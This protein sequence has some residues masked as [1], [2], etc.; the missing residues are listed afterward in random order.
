MFDDIP[1]IVSNAAL[2][3]ANLS[4]HELLRAAFSSQSGLLYRPISMLSF[5]FNLYFFGNNS[6]SFKLTNLFIHLV[7]A[8]LILWLTRRL[9]L[10]CRRR[11]QFEW[12]DNSINWASPLIAAAWALH[13]L[14][15]EPVLFI[16]QRMTELAALF[17]LAGLIAYIYGRE[18]MQAGK[19]GWPLVWILTPI[20][21]VIG[22]LCKEDAALLPLYLLVIEWLIFGFRNGHHKI[23]KNILLF[24][25]GGL[26]LPGILGLV[27]LLTHPGYFLGGY[28]GR[29]FTL[30]QRLLTEF[31]VVFLYIQWTFI[32]D[33]RQLALYHDDLTV[34]TGLLTPVTTLLSLLVLAG[35]LTL[36]WWQR[37]KRPLLSLGILF[38][39]AGQ[40]ME[41][42][43]L[44]LE[45]AF[46][47]RNYLPDFGLLLALFSLLLLPVSG[48]KRRAR[49][50]LRWIV[51]IVTLPVLFS[52]T[53]L[54]AYEWRS[55]LTFA[56]YE[57]QHHPESERALYVLGQTYSNLAL[58]GEIK[59]PAIAFQT[60]ERAAA[61]SSNI[62]P[63][64]A[65]M[66]VSA[67]LKLPVNPA[68]QKHAET[69]LLAHPV[70]VRDTTSLAS[71][72]DCLPMDCGTLA[73]T[74]DSLI[75]T[76]FQSSQKHHPSPDL[77][78]IYG[79]YL[80]F[81]GHPLVE[82]IAA[83]RQ[84]VKLAP[85]VPIYRISLTK[86]L[87]MAGEFDAAEEQISQL[88]RLNRLGN[89]DLEIKILEANLAAGRAEATKKKQPA[90]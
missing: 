15:L 3:L 5:A 51:A 4:P 90:G 89:L 46:E 7:N 57:V 58:S 22:L 65:M 75:K 52:A 39:F 12:Q 44:P 62:M 70:T 27:F 59:N 40:M 2:R 78:A 49:M 83:M 50:S 21:G 56:Y 6:F 1:N 34:S 66:M 16:V 76:A 28:A 42:T 61:I 38:F 80:T 69:L 82:V 60:L 23:S 81:T 19:T 14:N 35:M 54:R 36:A 8:L 85:R 79:N 87:I 71:L 10:N 48:G 77:W 18:R 47:H 53:L 13:P 86:G 67:K 20:L 26:I 74:A 68:W 25:A 31:R 64:V 17:T 33:I 41:S 88:S 11:Y 73:P 63:D 55:Y 30:P 72:V 29:D 9:L 24:Y 84:T 45:L 32:P 37:K 43:V